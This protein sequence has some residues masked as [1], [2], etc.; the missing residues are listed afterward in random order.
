[1]SLRPLARA[2]LLALALL[3]PLGCSSATPEPDD[4]YTELPTQTY[5]FDLVWQCAVEA[6]EA[7]GFAVDKSQRQGTGNGTLVTSMKQT[8]DDQ[9][10]EAE[11]GTRVRVRVTELGEQSYKLEVAPSRFQRPYKNAE[12]SYVGRDEQLLTRLKAHL[13]EALKKRYRSK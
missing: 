9:L 10:S 7:E 6:V 11:E 2:A 12:W 5:P 1:M 3:A 13:H 4:P 8:K